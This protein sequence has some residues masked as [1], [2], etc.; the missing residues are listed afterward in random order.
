MKAVLAVA[1]TAL[2][3]LALAED[4]A[5]AL[6]IERFDARLDAI[7]AR[8]TRVDVLADGISWAEGPLWDARS[9]ALLFS[10]VPRNAI[11]RWRAGAGVEMFLERSGYTGSAPFTGREPGSNG[12]AFDPEGRLV[13]C[14]HGERD[15]A[16]READGRIVV[17]ADRYRGKR[18][19]SPNDLVHRANGDLYFTDPPFGL[20]RTF[21]D[22]QKELSFQG[23]Y[24][25]ARDGTLTLLTTEL[26]SPNGLA[27]SPD[28]RV[29]YVS[30]AS[31]SRPIWMAYPM[32][33]DGSLGE[34]RVF[35]EASAYVQPGD[36]LPDGL[37]VDA[38]GNLFAAGPGGVHIF[39]SDGT[40]LGRIVTGVPTGNVAI[41]EGGRTLFIAANH[42]ILRV[43]LLATG[44]QPAS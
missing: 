38:R 35:A 6:R 12:L 15:I 37:K 25:L 3:S 26:D 28:E 17:L 31:R 41:G 8:E 39:A 24:R 40:P 23:V 18:L 21:D 4:S 5:S 14:R 19:N 36:G 34:G 27:F 43:P 7:I 13:Y 33:N 10:D 44:A 20:P 2:S 42:R 9:Q 30:N 16:R 32:R 22:P 1:L 29:L 11:F